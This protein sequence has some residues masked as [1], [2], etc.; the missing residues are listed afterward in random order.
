M[1]KIITF[2]ICAIVL[3]V[4]LAFSIA[5]RKMYRGVV[6]R[7]FVWIVAVTLASALFDVAA[8]ALEYYQVNSSWGIGL[9]YVCNSGYLIL[10]LLTSASYCVYVVAL[11]DTWHMLKQSKLVFYS[12]FWFCFVVVGLLISNPYTQFM[13]YYD[14]NYMY[15]RGSAFWILYVIA[16]VYVSFS[17]IYLIKYR[18]LFNKARLYGLL[19]IFPLNLVAVLVQFFDGRLLI[20]LFFNAIALLFITFTVQRVEENIDPVT[21]IRNYQAFATDMKRNFLT[22]KNFKLIIIKI[23]NY[24]S[25]LTLLGYDAMNEL[26]CKVADAMSDVSSDTKGVNDLYNLGMGSF[27]FA[28]SRASINAPDELAAKING[29]MIINKMDINVASYICVADCPQEVASF[30]TL[31]NITNNLDE[32]LP[33]PN[34]VY[35]V[36]DVI[37][38]DI[39]ELSSEMDA[40]IERAFINRSF[41][42]YYQPIYSVEKK[43]FVSA[44]ALLRLKD[45]QYGFISPAIFIPAAEKSGAIHR[46]GDYVLD[47]VCRFIGSEDFAKTGLDYI[48]V[49]LSVAQCMQS[50]LSERVFAALNKYNV[51]ADKLNIEITETAMSYSQQIILDNLDKLNNAGISISLDDYGTGYSNIMRVASLPLKIV[52][53]DK[54]FADEV[55]NPRMMIVLENTIA[56]LK[57][58]N[59]E[60]VV[61]GI[62]TEN[63]AK[64]FADYKCEYIQGY[65]YSRPIPKKELMEFLQK[66]KQN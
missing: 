14:E 3:L 7:S 47:E 6:G 1:D 52:K 45:E 13:F 31:M 44:E 16:F 43:G 64:Q 53:L 34:S 35:N 56:M 33:S 32:Y 19:A 41:E 28:T 26:M 51:T 5:Y 2:D 42:V 37:K 22:A 66:F 4:V 29:N 15:V 27:C 65:Y 54:G 57:K 39:F 46:I 20:E 63:V 55:H 40:I 12:L 17:V 38:K 50:D 10:H 58:M 36:K 60:I 30:K 8:V 49:N 62:E 18:R 23:A 59:L 11:T 24:D 25:L 9:R 61:E 21:G 48:E